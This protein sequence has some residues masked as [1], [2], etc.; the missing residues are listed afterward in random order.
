MAVLHT[1]K[2]HCAYCGRKFSNNEKVYNNKDEDM[3]FCIPPRNYSGM[4]CTERFLA[5]HGRP[6]YFDEAIVDECF[7][8]WPEYIDDDIFSK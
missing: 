5:K 6:I 2:S 4:S 8:D 7:V 3:A 1:N